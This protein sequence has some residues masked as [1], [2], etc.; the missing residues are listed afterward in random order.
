[1]WSGLPRPGASVQGNVSDSRRKTRGL[2][3][4]PLP[5]VSSGRSQAVNGRL[6]HKA[7]LLLLV[8]LALRVSRLIMEGN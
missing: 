5:G 6:Q 4:P 8:V 1:M 3:H 2:Q 7:V